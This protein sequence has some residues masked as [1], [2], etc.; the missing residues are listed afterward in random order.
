MKKSI[1]NLGKALERAEQKEIAGGYGGG[2]GTP[3]CCIYS[4]TSGYQ[5]GYSLNHAQFMMQ[6]PHVISYE[7]F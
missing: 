4:T 1:L 7:C 3:V 5:C 2:G 6:L